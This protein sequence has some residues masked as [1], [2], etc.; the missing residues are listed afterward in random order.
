MNVV[1]WIARFVLPN[2]A[3]NDPNEKWKDHQDPPPPGK[4]LLGSLRL[5]KPV[6]RNWGFDRGLPVDRYYI[7]RFL[8]GSAADIRGRVLEVKSGVYTRTFGGSRVIS[9][10]VLNLVEGNP[11]A[12]IVGDLAKLEH[13]AT[14]S[15]DCMILTQT[16]QLI[17][18]VRAA[19]KTVYRILRPG[20][21]L[22]LTVPG[23]SKIAE[24]DGEGWE[25]CWRFTTFSTRR[26]L[27]EV[28]HR[29]NVLVESRGNVL[30]SIAFLHGLS[31]GELTEEELDYQDMEFQVLITARAVKS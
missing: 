15:F 13:I 29:S 22:L 16:L 5:V 23:I 4:L 26:L 18:D 25:D 20:G 11:D 24:D 27:E 1:R 19:L 6:S 8:A 7:E 9:S 30:A 31:A 2:P 21:T 3:M 12:T 17:F 28:F 10:D 14:N